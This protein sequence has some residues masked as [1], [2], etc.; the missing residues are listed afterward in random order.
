MPTRVKTRCVLPLAANRTFR[1]QS[2]SSLDRAGDMPWRRKS[3]TPFNVLLL[4][5][6][7]GLVREADVPERLKP[8]R[9]RQETSDDLFSQHAVNRPQ[10]GEQ[11]RH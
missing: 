8:S 5:D 6:A 3:G 2:A 11:H 1:C 4:E 9:C 10:I 7:N